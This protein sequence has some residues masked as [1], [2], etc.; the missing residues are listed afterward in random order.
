MGW[1]GGGNVVLLYD[2]SADRDA[3]A[4]DHFIQA[5]KVLAQEQDLAASIEA[6]LNRN[7]ENAMAAAFSMGSFQI[8]NLA[9]PSANAD[10]VNASSVAENTLQYGGT[11]V[12]SVGVA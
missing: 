6:C 5:D 10:A 9:D 7:G 2:W 4:P 8:N 1:N 11:S 12:G 3:G